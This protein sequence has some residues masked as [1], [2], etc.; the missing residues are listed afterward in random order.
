MMFS[1]P[2]L[3]QKQFGADISMHSGTKYL[4][5]H[6]DALL[7]VLTVSPTTKRGRELAPKIKTVQIGVGG[8]ASPWD[9]WLT[10]RGLRTLHVRVERQ[11]KT[12]KILTEYLDKHAM[13][14]AVHYPG[15]A[16]HPFHHVAKS[17]MDMFGGVFS[18]ELEDEVTATAFAAALQTI[19]RAT[20]L[21]GT[22]TL[23]E[24]RASIEPPERRTSP[25][26][27]LRVSVGLEDENDLLRDIEQALAVAEQ[28]IRE[29]HA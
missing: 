12:A 20:S 3:C 26:G 1:E 9:S 25:P 11:S 6:S 27:L 8:V 15:L 10:M 13:V 24:H 5:G 18:V 4:A 7:G 17:Q 2:F 14:K 21:G 16:S 22:E 29:S 19:Q 23:I 28:V